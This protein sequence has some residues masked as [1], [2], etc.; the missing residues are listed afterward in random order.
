MKEAKD[1]VRENVDSLCPITGSL[2]RGQACAMRSAD[3]T[4]DDD[5]THSRVGNVAAYFESREK[6]DT[7]D[8]RLLHTAKQAWPTR[9]PRIKMVPTLLVKQKSSGT[10]ARSNTLQARPSFKAI[11]SKLQRTT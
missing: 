3:P 10:Y 7:L 8:T 11:A 5:K 4:A 1:E 2:L 9:T 6:S